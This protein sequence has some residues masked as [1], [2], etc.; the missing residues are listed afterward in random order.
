MREDVDLGPASQVELRAH[1]Q[2]VEAGLGHFRA[3]FTRESSVQRFAQPVQVEQ[4]YYPNYE[5]IVVGDTAAVIAVQAMGW[6]KRAKT[7]GFDEANISSARNA[8]I[9]VAAGEI[10]AFVDDDAVPEPSWLDHI[11]EAFEMPNVGAVGGYV[12]GR[13]GIAFQ[14]KAN[15]VDHF[16]ANVPLDAAGK[17]PFKPGI[18]EG[19]GV[20][21]EGTNCAFRRDILAEMGGFDPTYR[22]FHDDADV[23]MRL[24]RE[25]VETALA[26]S[27]QVH[28]GL[29]AS[30]TRG[31]DNTP[32]SLFEI[33]ASHMVFLR[34][35]CPRAQQEAAIEAFREGQRKRLLRAMVAG[36]LEPRDIAPIEASLDDGLEEGRTRVLAK[37]EPL[38]PADDTFLRFERKGATH[39]AGYIVGRAGNMRHLA[40]MA[41][42]RVR[43]GDV[44]TLLTLEPSSR[45]HR[46]RFHPDGF[47]HQSG[48]MF[49]PSMEGDKRVRLHRFALRAH[50]ESTRIAYLRQSAHKNKKKEEK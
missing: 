43:R 2:E 20:K 27:A 16:G 12:R 17:D 5:I 32:K 9:R 49:G 29:A 15:L 14:Y 25:D 7:V 39:R 23:N 30:T 33:A 50:R 24:T 34:K 46:M 47:W 40:Q 6:S 26:P 18:P 4:L 42:V 3:P 48:G 13:N 22:Y 10:V 31:A 19:F 44:M 1:G 8:G 28:H 35:Y 45:P 41:R 38:G 37:L 36:G 21:T 11:A